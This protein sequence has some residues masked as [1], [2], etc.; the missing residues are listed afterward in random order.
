M[1]KLD[2]KVL[3]LLR[4]KLNVSYNLEK[5]LVK[6]NISNKIDFST[7]L[8]E[9][10]DRDYKEYLEREKNKMTEITEIENRKIF[11][12]KLYTLLEY[13]EKI[14]TSTL[15]INEILSEIDID[16]VLNYQCIDKSLNINFDNYT[17]F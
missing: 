7:Q 10:I 14:E 17:W 15:S 13:F 1:V 12:Q 11:I 9:L 8:I 4:D 2:A 3:L 6:D 16:L 5:F